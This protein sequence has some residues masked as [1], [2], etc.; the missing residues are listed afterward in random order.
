MESA[1]EKAALALCHGP[2]RQMQSR[3]WQ[4][5]GGSS[6][7]LAV[8][9]WA[10]RVCSTRLCV[11]IVLLHM[12]CMLLADS[13]WNE[14]IM[15]QLFEL[16]LQC[17]WVSVFVFTP[18]NTV[19]FC[20]KKDASFLTSFGTTTLWLN[21]VKQHVTSVSSFMLLVVIQVYVIII[22]HLLML[23]SSRKA[24]LPYSYSALLRNNNLWKSWY[25]EHAMN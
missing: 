19:F 9:G 21:R 23:E 7:L 10:V 15:P 17:I 22:Q 3:V 20:L 12:A 4:T 11:L 18:T 13:I 16:I 1:S 25:K 14:A 2:V 6:N 8:G 5:S 24:C